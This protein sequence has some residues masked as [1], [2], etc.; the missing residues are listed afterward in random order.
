MPQFLNISPKA[1]RVTTLEDIHNHHQSLSHSDEEQGS[2]DPSPIQVPII[3]IDLNSSSLRQEEGEFIEVKRKKKGGP[4]K[5][6]QS[7][8]TREK[9]KK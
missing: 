9:S 7:R 4:E 2:E 5:D 6:A 8:M 3:Q 1:P